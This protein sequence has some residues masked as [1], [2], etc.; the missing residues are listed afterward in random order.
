[1][2][3]GGIRSAVRAASFG[4]KLNIEYN[5]CLMTY[6]IVVSR[7]IWRDARSFPPCW[8]F[9]TFS[10]SNC[11]TN[12]ILARN[13]KFPPLSLLLSLFLPRPNSD[14]FLVSLFQKWNV[15]PSRCFLNVFQLYGNISLC[16][17]SRGRRAVA[18]RPFATGTTN[19]T[20]EQSNGSSTR[21]Q[22][23]DTRRP[24]P[25]PSVRLPVHPLRWDASPRP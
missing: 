5:H 3:Y 24:S 25:P 18:A 12:P 11:N 8:T 4:Y 14:P 17:R 6:S 20:A 13:L 19:C 2:L 1:M 15:P 9:V 22:S 10:W 23:E 21:T 16:H 7:N